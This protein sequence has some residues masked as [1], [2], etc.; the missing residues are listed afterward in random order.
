MP[1]ERFSER[2]MDRPADIIDDREILW[3]KY[4][5][6]AVIWRAPAWN[7][8]FQWKHSEIL[9]ARL[10]VLSRSHF[11]TISTIAKS[12]FQKSYPVAQKKT[13]YFW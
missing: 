13:D 5:S 9:Q 7:G 1:L 12:H 2:G 8:E 4:K 10:T 3:L 6:E 11:D